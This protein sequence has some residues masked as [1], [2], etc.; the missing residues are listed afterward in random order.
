MEESV[1][2]L[3]QVDETLLTQKTSPS[4]LHCPIDSDLLL[5]NSQSMVH[6]FSRPEHVSNIRPATNPI[7]AH[8][9]K[10][11]LETTTE[12]DFDHTPVYFDSRGITNV[13]SLYRLGQKFCVKYDSAD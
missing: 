11:V 3:A 10:G 2:I 12:A 5:L 9:N 6:L 13:L 4:P 7:R 1:A 8:C